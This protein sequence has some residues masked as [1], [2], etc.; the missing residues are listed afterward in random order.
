VP[1]PLWQDHLVFSLW[2]ALLVLLSVGSQSPRDAYAHAV[3][4]EAEGNHPAAL[5]LLW[6]VAGEAPKDAEVQNRLGE[7]LDR[8]GALE[9]AIDAYKRALANRPDFTRAANNLVLALAAAGRGGEAVDFARRRVLLAPADPEAHFT[10]GLAQ[11]EQNVDEAVRTF[12][13]VIGMRPGHALAHYNL[14]L[15]LKRVD[16]ASE[17]IASLLRAND[18]EPRA[19]TFFAIGTIHFQQG[20]IERALG[21]LDAA[22]KLDPRNADAWIA[23]G[24]VFKARGELPL[25]VDA[26]RR[27]LAL[28]PDSW[29]ARST[30]ATVL[31]LAGEDE[32]A[33]QEALEAERR[34][35]AGQA[36]REAA[37]LTAV[38][39]ARLDGGDIAAAAE[40]FQRAIAVHG[41]YAPAHYQLGRALR[42]LGRIDDARSAFAK[43]RQL[44]PS[45]M[46]PD[47]VK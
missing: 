9:G 29:S 46:P 45:L 40:H 17:A 4:L 26:L 20:D 14:G 44:N 19:E 8:I 16:R 2:P 10:L 18:I 35:T 12:R 21:A 34:R 22:V 13:H 31:R 27:A 3:A 11:S 5:S 36:E 23:R 38:G 1:V 33:R 24:A 42:A 41:S 15:V 43:A 39:I 6:V 25:A 32:A 7:A 30:L 47:G 37:V 28:R